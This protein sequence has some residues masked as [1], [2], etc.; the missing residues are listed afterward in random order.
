M[1]DARHLRAQARIY[2]NL[3]ERNSQSWETSTLRTM[4][5]EC[6]SDAERL[7][8]SKRSGNTGTFPAA[9][10]TNEVKSGH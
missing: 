3:A 5:A 7:E 6:I 2:L 8:T 1:Q 4:A 10:R 9:L